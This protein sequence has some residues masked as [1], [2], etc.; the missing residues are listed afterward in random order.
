MEAKLLVRILP[1]DLACVV[2]SGGDSVGAAV[3]VNPEGA[4]AGAAVDVNDDRAER[5]L[6]SP[7]HYRASEYYKNAQ[8]HPPY[9]AAYVLPR[10]IFL[11][12]RNA[13]QVVKHYVSSI[14]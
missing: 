13:S 3:D 7:P 14:S 1:Y 12:P 10:G 6:L 9:P 4:R 5:D 8:E 2:D 11:P